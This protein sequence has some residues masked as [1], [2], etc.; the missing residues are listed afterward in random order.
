MV[1]RRITLDWSERAA[2][3]NPSKAATAT[4]IVFIAIS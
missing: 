1:W 4:H 2:P 3:T